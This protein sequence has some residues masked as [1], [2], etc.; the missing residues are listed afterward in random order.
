MQFFSGS[1]LNVI[2][3]RCD[4]FLSATFL[5]LYWFFIV[6]QLLS[7]VQLFATR[8]T[9]LF[10]GRLNVQIQVYLTLV[11]DADIRSSEMKLITYIFF[12]SLENLL[13]VRQVR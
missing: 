2:I 9:Q 3:I 7:H 11:N 12:F 6:V 8:W 4:I 10:N 13:R 1:K 5:I